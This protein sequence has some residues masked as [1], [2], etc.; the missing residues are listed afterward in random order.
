MVP[1]PRIKA[2]LM[3]DMQANSPAQKLRLPQLNQTDRAQL[4]GKSLVAD[5]LDLGPRHVGLKVRDVLFSRLVGK[6]QL[7][8]S[9]FVN[10]EDDGR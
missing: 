4:R 3:K 9:P 6:D 7:S 5:P 1:A 2:V 8:A 10:Y